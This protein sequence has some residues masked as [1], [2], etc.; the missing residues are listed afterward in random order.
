MNQGTLRKSYK[1]VMEMIQ[2]RGYSI[3]DDAPN[4]ETYSPEDGYL[5]VIGFEKGEPALLVSFLIGKTKIG[6][7]DM[8]PFREMMKNHEVN[9]AIFIFGRCDGKGDSI[10]D[11]ARD[12]V[13]DLKIQN[14]FMEIFTFIET[15]INI[16]RTF[17]IKY[18]VL[19]PKEKSEVLKSYGLLDKQC[20]CIIIP[21]DPLGV[22]YGMMPGDMLEIT[23][24]GEPPTY[25]IARQKQS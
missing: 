23:R 13:K 7:A 6:T 20:P 19:T 8:I 3:L 25:R 22:Y 1:T 14:C 11:P 18:K 5:E 24:P 16:C 10:S 17:N 2:D 9:K 12:M 15:Q 21:L 4:P